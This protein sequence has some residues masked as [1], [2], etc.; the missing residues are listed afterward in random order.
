MR[1]GL[2]MLK[3]FSSKVFPSFQFHSRNLMFE[4][5][6]LHKYWESPWATYSRGRSRWRNQFLVDYLQKAGIERSK[7]QVASHVQVLRNMWKGEK[8]RTFIGAFP[9]VAVSDSLPEYHLVAGGEELFLET[10][11]LAPVKKEDANEFNVLSPAETDD[12]YLISPISP[13]GPGFEPPP[14]KFEDHSG[15]LQMPSDASQPA[16][17]VGSADSHAAGPSA[18]L[19]NSM[20]R[21]RSS[22]MPGLHRRGPPPIS[23]SP[24]AP[25]P[26]SSSYDVQTHQ[27]GPPA[28]ISS[29]GSVPFLSAD[30][31]SSSSVASS[32]SPARS[33]EIEL[34]NRNSL[35]HESPLPSPV[36]VHSPSPPAVNRITSLNLFAEGMQ[37]F[38]IPLNTEINPSAQSPPR[39]LIRI[40]LRLPS[41][42]DVH[43]SPT[44]HGVH[45][46]VSLARPWTTS[47]SCTTDVYVASVHHSRDTASLQPPAI[48]ASTAESTAGLP[49]SELTRCRWLDSCTCF[50]YLLTIALCLMPPTCFFFIYLAKQTIIYQRVVVDNDTMAVIVYDLDRSFSDNSPFAQ[51]ETVQKY[52][53][54]SEK[55]YTPSPISP[56]S[57]Y[58]N[59]GFASHP[60]CPPPRVRYPEQTSLSCALTPIASRSKSPPAYTARTQM[61]MDPSGMM[62]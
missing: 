53:V 55:T 6:G 4:Y 30:A 43:G 9:S 23:S 8:G 36:I 59:Y 50:T 19:M 57:P 17:P 13:S 37:P 58:S 47:A 52:R 42:D 26:A 32:S 18:G 38:S 24:L 3:R 49:E 54:N 11:L 35:Y 31:Q 5:L 62:Y 60:R 7:K 51:V 29:G 39:L 40:K 15:L 46:T 44:L 2:R 14:F 12:S 56:S 34:P 28:S 48:D 45:G 25:R 16:S 41:I 1:Y 20:S 21:G 22:S 10:G 33:Y 27:H 61:M